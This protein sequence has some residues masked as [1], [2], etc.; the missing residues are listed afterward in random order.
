MNQ[1]CKAEPVTGSVEC[2]IGLLVGLSS[3][4]KLANSLMA[5]ALHPKLSNIIMKKQPHCPPMTAIHSGR[6]LILTNYQLSPYSVIG[7]ESYAF[8]V[9]SLY[10]IGIA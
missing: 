3:M 4:P 6:H 7:N 5:L 10:R 1:G 8:H 2:K 9:K